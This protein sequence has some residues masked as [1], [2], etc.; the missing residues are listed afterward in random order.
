[1]VDV[2][3][4]GGNGRK[5]TPAVGVSKARKKQLLRRQE[6]LTASIQEAEARVAE[7]DE[8]FCEPTFYERAS[9]H[10]VKILETERTSLQSD[11]ADLT[12]EWE[13]AEE[14]IG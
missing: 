11:V 1:V 14:E 4:E 8:V 2:M 10:E 12:S 5:A 7:I 3:V 13:R 9:L 6:G